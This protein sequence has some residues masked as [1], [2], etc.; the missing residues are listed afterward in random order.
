MKIK[1]SRSFSASGMKS[2]DF[3]DWAMG[4]LDEGLKKEIQ[5]YK[6]KHPKEELK[7]CKY[8]IKRYPEK[9]GRILFDK[10]AVFDCKIIDI[11][12][13]KSNK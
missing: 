12:N 6:D 4:L 11:N 7:E 13:I 1:Y 9:D 3:K 8:E 2:I 5:K 10:Y